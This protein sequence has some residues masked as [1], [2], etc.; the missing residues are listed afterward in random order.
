MGRSPGMH[1]LDAHTPSL[2]HHEPL[3]D[4]RP[5][6]ARTL[7]VLGEEGGYAAAPRPDT[8]L[9]LGRNTPDVHV[10]IGARDWHVSREHAVL[11]CQSDGSWVLRN[12]GRLPIRIPDAPALLRE[13][14]APLPGGYTPLYIQGTRLH[15]VELLIST[16]HQA[17]D[18]ARPD[19]GTRDLSWPLNPRERLVL[20]A[21]FQSY[22]LR[23]DEAHP[24]SWKET[25][26]WL[27]EVPGQR[28]WTDRKAEHV[29][30]TVR[31][32]LVA[33]GVGGI[34]A[35]SA[36]PEAIKHNLLRV[37]TESATLTPPD[38]RLLDTGIGE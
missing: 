21:L 28:G 17:A 2:S 27:N 4:G 34:T 11:R 12:G 5:A 29:V 37:L 7:F 23:A 38:L 19:A 33:G 8:R 30:D 24:L 25:S 6:P 10:S 36:H 18:E 32:R 3:L 22:L 16:G 14:E 13:H 15:V 20:V 26:R 35:D 1:V 31:R 9:V